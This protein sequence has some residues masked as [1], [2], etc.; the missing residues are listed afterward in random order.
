MFRKLANR[1]EMVN[2]N[3]LA[4]LELWIKDFIAVVKRKPTSASFDTNYRVASVVCMAVYFSSGA[5]FGNSVF[6]M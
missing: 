3:Q 2:A 1:K 5:H 6:I 4:D